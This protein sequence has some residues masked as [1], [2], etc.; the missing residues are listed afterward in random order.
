MSQESPKKTEEA[1]PL[2]DVSY[3]PN[4]SRDP[5]FLNSFTFQINNKND[6]T[7][8]LTQP[9]DNAENNTANE[10]TGLEEKLSLEKDAEAGQTS[11]RKSITA[12]II[13]AEDILEN[14]KIRLILAVVCAI[15][16]FM[17]V[18]VLSIIL[19]AN[20]SVRFATQCHAAVSLTSI[21][22]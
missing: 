4:T 22:V 2:E 8:P 3:L 17:L 19:I 5:F 15:L 10:T 9:E 21:L 6:E 11:K 18:L 14:P 20:L 12:A 16:L 13:A 7:T 1:Y